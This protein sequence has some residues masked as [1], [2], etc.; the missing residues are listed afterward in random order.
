VRHNVFGYEFKGSGVQIG[1]EKK[2][3]VGIGIKKENKIP[4]L[5]KQNSKEPSIPSLKKEN[6]IPSTTPP[7]KKDFS[8]ISTGHHYTPPQQPAEQQTPVLTGK[9]TTIGGQS[10]GSSQTKTSLNT[11]PTYSTQTQSQNKPTPSL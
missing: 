11:S 2:A 4:S 6:S 3:F 5:S 7:L 9:G 10:S 1:G 8:G